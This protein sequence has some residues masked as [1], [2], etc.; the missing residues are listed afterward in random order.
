MHRIYFR[1]LQEDGNILQECV[2]DVAETL[3]YEICW[4]RASYAELGRLS[5]AKSQA[6][7]QLHGVASQDSE[8]STVSEPSKFYCLHS[9]FLVIT[10]T[11]LDYFFE[12][13][14]ILFFR[15]APD[16]KTD[17]PITIDDVIDS[18]NQP[19]HHLHRQGRVQKNFKS[20]KRNFIKKYCW[21]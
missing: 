1:I 11:T 2:I 8:V 10:C 12:L 15:N 17:A 13:L 5:S 6:P 4:F 3:K 14:N 19:A 9:T 20:S 21:L 7:L 16:D 18:M